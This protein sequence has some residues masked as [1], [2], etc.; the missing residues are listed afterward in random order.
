MG[1][2]KQFPLFVR[3]KNWESEEDLR[4][5]QATRHVEVNDMRDLW[6]DTAKLKNCGGVCPKGT[7]IQL[8]HQKTIASWIEEKPDFFTRQILVTIQS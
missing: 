1:K 4:S 7:K 8:I 5:W 6:R 3:S 2:W